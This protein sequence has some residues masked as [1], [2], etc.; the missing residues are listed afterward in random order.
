MF[1]ALLY[2]YL[3]SSGIKLY[4]RLW[5][6][7]HLT[8]HV[9]FTK[10]KKL[11]IADEIPAVRAY[12]R[13]PPPSRFQPGGSSTELSR[14]GLSDE[15]VFRQRC[16]SVAWTLW[17]LV[18]FPAASDFF[19]RSSPQAPRWVHLILSAKTV[20]EVWKRSLASRQLVSR[21]FVPDRWFGWNCA[22]AH[23]KCSKNIIVGD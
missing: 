13:A 7:S 21:V 15:G 6:L 17:K 18:E 20:Y 4:F 1:A 23:S 14:S 12:A 10:P 3:F 8:A 22:V 19:L 11:R 16:S 5:I 2:I 9:V